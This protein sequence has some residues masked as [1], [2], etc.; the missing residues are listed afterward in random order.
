L[1]SDALSLLVIDLVILSCLMI[2]LGSNYCL[3]AY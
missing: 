3:L 1:S 2:Y